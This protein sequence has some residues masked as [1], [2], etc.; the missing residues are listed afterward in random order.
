[1]LPVSVVIPA[2]NRADLLPRALASVHAQSTPPAEVIVVDDASA[3][4]T[5]KVAED[6]GALV[7]AHDRNRGESA[8]R[9]TAIAAATQPWIALLDSDDEWL[10]GHLDR[11]FGLRDGHVLVA[12]AALG[13]GPVSSDHR[14]YGVVARGPV[15]L[16][17][18]VN[19]AF[20]VNCVPPSSALVRREAVLGLGGF[21]AKQQLC[22]DL[23]MW[24]R[25]LERGT[26]L[27]SPAVGSVYHIHPGQAS[28]DSSAM[29]RAHRDVL[30]RYSGR[31]W[32]KP[33]LLRRYDG[34][35]LWDALRAAWRSGDPG[36]AAMG[37]L[38]IGSHPD[39]VRGVLAT[40]VWRLRTRRR[41]LRIPLAGG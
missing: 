36:A 24:L 19:V 16:R 23:D 35:A 20:P 29:H 7:I 31:P 25:L 12:D 37:L 10:P 13:R 8:A 14:I 15:L 6:L 40:L 2:Y 9:N 3:D 18:P 21:D 38:R 1:V 33:S 28:H 4:D 27:A 22:A 17:S 41:S 11:V 26:G 39:R 34:V 30:A 32:W 5:A